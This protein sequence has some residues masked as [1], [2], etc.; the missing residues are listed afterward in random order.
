[1]SRIIQYIDVDQQLVTIN[2]LD[3]TIKMN[4]RRR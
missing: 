2:I 3:K 4:K 1:M